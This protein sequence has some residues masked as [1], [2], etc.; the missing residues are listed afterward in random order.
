MGWKGSTATPERVFSRVVDTVIRQA[1]CEVLVAKLSEQSRF[2]R[3]LVPIARGPNAKEAVR[4]LPALT[5]LADTPRIYICQVFKP[6]TAP[7]TT[8][9]E[10]AVRFVKKLKAQVVATPVTTVSVPEAIIS[11]AR[12]ES[13][14]VI[15]V[16]A[17]REGLL[18]QV[19]KGNIPETIARKSSC[20]VLL[21][22]KKH[23]R[24]LT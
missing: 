4:L 23:S 1:P 9:L 12:Q 13:S 21:V 16:G 14:D 6:A 22:I 3:W 7:D 18:Q 20:T 2:D 19:I 11:L 8:E 5:S 17:S 24:R 10:Q 15:V